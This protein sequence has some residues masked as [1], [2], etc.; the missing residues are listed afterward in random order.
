MN[1]GTPLSAASASA[2]PDLL[3]QYLP[4]EL[5]AKLEAA[6]AHGGS[7]RAGERR[8]ITMLFCDIK[9]STAAAGQVDPEIWTDVMNGAFERMIRPIYQYEGTVPRLMGDAILAFF[10]APIAHE[11]DP[12]RAVWAGLD[13]QARMQ[14]YADEMRSRFGLDFGLRVGIN[15]GLVVV[16]E[17]GSD[18]RME[19]TAIGDAINL[20]A[21]MEQTAAPGTVQI[22]EETHKLIAPLFDF[23]PLGGIDV[24]G[25]SQPVTAYR[26]LGRKAQPGQLRGL[27][28][29]SSPLV[30]RDEQLALL[31]EQLSALE[32]GQGGFVAVIGEAGLGK[33]SLVDAIQKDLTARHA[34]NARKDSNLKAS[35]L[36]ELGP[37]GGEI[38]SLKSPN[39]L[40]GEAFSYSRS[41]SYFPWRQIIRRSIGARDDDAPEHVRSLLRAQCDSGVLTADDLPFLEAM[42]A[43]E[44]DE[45]RQVLAD[46]QAEALVARMTEAARGYLAALARECP[47]VLV[48]D[49]LHWADEA[50]LNLLLSAS[51]LA[52]GQPILF[53]CMLRPDHDAPSWRSM[54]DIES[55]LGGRFRSIT[56]QPLDTTHTDTLL[57]N[58][59]GMQG[60]PPKLRD[61]IV[62]KAGGNPFFVE[63]L[64]RS[65]IETRQIVRENSHWRL[66]SGDASVSVPETLR[67]VLGARID[68]LPEPSRHILQM[69]S[70]IGRSFDLRVLEHFARVDELDARVSQL[71]EAGLV[72]GR[73]AQGEMAFRHVLIQEAAYDS[74][75]M[76]QRPELH[77]RVGESLEELHAGRIEEF[78]PLL[79]HHFYAAQDD[80]SLKYDLLA[81]EKAAR[82]YANAEAAT[83]FRRALET[84]RRTG[85]GVPQLADLYSRLGGVLELAGRYAEAL[86]TYD[87][88]QA[89][90]REHQAPSMELN[91]LMAKGTLY[92]TP[93]ELRDPDMGEKTMLQAIELSGA[94]ADLAVQTRLNWNMMLNY[95]HSRRLQLAFE[96]GQKAL[97]LARAAGDSNQLAFVLNDMGRVLICRGDFNGA[98]ADIH[99]ARAIWRA[100]DNRVM[101]AD[102]LGAEEEGQL[103]LGN[104]DVMIALARQALEMCESLDN[105]WGKSYHRLLLGLAYF[106]KGEPW[107][108]IRLIEE[109]IELG[110]Q[111]GLI[112]SRIAGRCDLAWFYGWCGAIDKGLELIE[113]A[114]ESARANLPD[115]VVMPIA[116]KVRLHALRGDLHAAEE[117]ASVIPLE[118]PSLP[119]QHYTMMVRHAQIELAC[120]RGDYQ[121]ALTTIDAALSEMVNIVRSEMPE[122]MGRRGDILLALRRP[123]E[124]LRMLLEARALAE[125]LDSKQQLWS[126]LA[127]L[128]DV[129]SH[130]GQ[131]SEAKAGRE[132][133]LQILEGIAEGLEDAGLREG[134]MSLARVRELFASATR[135]KDD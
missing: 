31:R 45:S 69:A 43:V 59:L 118:P 130:L 10:G 27:D 86:S 74:I 51:D 49:D 11:D 115:W 123:E 19:Y 119:Y 106:E 100:S 103:A 126:V 22:T 64:I 107:T 99:E 122:V 62:E 16:G 108:A 25:K 54:Q 133:A 60:L 28:G 52:T 37:L 71:Q 8:V 80:R 102:S 34:K 117:A 23:E 132:K 114:I 113:P 135:S 33:S 78:A 50:S 128:S 76:K 58:L 24:K 70:V 29:L 14:P 116:V 9:G 44:S 85:A 97:A 18:L 26:V 93:T 79:A 40:K 56:L 12:Q 109:G 1:C 39:W 6:R 47:L 55:R 96:Y 134:F 110:D 73:P 13:I 91:A 42:L 30:G 75:L 94:V 88:M 48:F 129:Q 89:F 38:S 41:V 92:S 36:G 125:A 127:S 120:L 83:H 66:A 90:A 67:G 20:A 5:V 2:T 68:R 82:L 7:Q 46:F 98:F 124:A 72:E 17:I 53:L 57:A 35:S 61:L 21:R 63:E 95:L 81:G 104:F 87:H 4:P 15:T 121:H 77:R 112:I 3:G 32:A 101:L 131:L 111:G 65:L 105:A 84:A